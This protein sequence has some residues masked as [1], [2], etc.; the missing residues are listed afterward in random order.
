MVQWLGLHASIAGGT[1]SIPVAGE[2]RSHKLCNKSK[3]KK[4]MWKARPGKEKYT[5]NGEAKQK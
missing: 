4:K 2:L 1:G 5:V 3:K